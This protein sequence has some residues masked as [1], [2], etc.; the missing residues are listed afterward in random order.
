MEVKQPSKLGMSM[1][2]I[3]QTSQS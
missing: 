2:T 1:G 3:S